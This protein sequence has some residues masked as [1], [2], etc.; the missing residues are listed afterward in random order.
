MLFF[1][2]EKEA[3]GIRAQMLHVSHRLMCWILGLQCL[4]LFFQNLET[5]GHRTYLEEVAHCGCIFQGWSWSLNPSFSSLLALRGQALPM[6]CVPSTMMLMMF[7]TVLLEPSCRLHTREQWFTV[8]RSASKLLLFPMVF[9]FIV[10]SET[11][12]IYSLVAMCA[13]TYLVLAFQLCSTTPSLHGH[14]S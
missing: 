10:L 2:V 9:Y 13:F 14:G 8:T 1:T 12:L 4:V 6:S 3:L 5:L 11:S 7:Y